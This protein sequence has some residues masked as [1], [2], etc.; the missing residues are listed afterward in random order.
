MVNSA[1]G[2]RLAH[3][4]SP[5]ELQTRADITAA[6]DKDDIFSTPFMDSYDEVGGGTG[7]ADDDEEEAVLSP[8]A[9]KVSVKSRS[10]SSGSGGSRG[11]GLR[12]ATRAQ[13]P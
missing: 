1:K 9:S 13:C 12:S 7:D 8:G 6:R 3:S 4:L 11:D 2:F 5:E 10:G